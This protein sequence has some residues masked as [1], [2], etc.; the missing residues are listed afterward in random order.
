MLMFLTLYGFFESVSHQTAR[1]QTA[2]HHVI[3]VWRQFVHPRAAMA[4]R[5]SKLARDADLLRHA[6]TESALR[7]SRR[8][9]WSLGEALATHSVSRNSSS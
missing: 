1:Y 2:T 6:G 4:T 5:A 9:R 3:F 8:L 7:S